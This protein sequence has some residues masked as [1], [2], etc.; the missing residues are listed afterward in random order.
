MSDERVFTR[1]V[2]DQYHEK[3]VPCYE[4]DAEGMGTNAASGPYRMAPV[5][6]KTLFS[7]K[8]AAQII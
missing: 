5:F 6:G 7:G 1:A 8:K 4:F 2:I 3:L